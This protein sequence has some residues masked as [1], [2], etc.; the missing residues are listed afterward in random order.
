ML[1]DIIALLGIANPQLALAWQDGGVPTE[2][3]TSPMRLLSNATNGE[4]HAPAAGLFNQDFAKLLS[5]PNGSPPTG[6]PWVLA[7]HPQVGLRLARL[8]GGVLEG[9]TTQ[10]DRVQRPLP[11][12]FAFH[13]TT[14]VGGGPQAGTRAPGERL[15]L[16]GGSISVHDAA[17]QPIDALATACAFA[18]LLTTFPAL[19]AKDF[20][21]TTAPNVASSQLGQLAAALTGTEVRVRLV[22]LFRNPFADG[23]TKLTNLTAIDAAA[24]IYR[25]TN[26]AQPVLV[27]FPPAN[28]NERIAVGAATFGT[29]DST[30]SPQPLGPAV[31]LTTLKRDFLTVFADDLNGHLRGREALVAPYA[32]QDFQIPT[33]HN[34]N[35][36]LLANGNQ[37]LAQAGQV[38]ANA[39]GLSLVVSPVIASDFAVAANAGVSEWPIFPSGGDGAIAGRLQNVALNAHFLAAPADTRDVVLTMEIPESAPSVP[40]LAPGTAVRIYNRKFLADAREGRGNGAGGVLDA[41]RKIGFVLTNPFGLRRDE[42]LPTSPK[43]LFDLIAVNRSGKK[44]SFGL[45]GTDVAAPR[46]PDAAESALADRGAN[47]FNSAPER[48][49]APAGLLGLPAPALSTIPPI[50]DLNSAIDAALSLGDETQPR[51]AP[52][53]PTMTRNELIVA[54][55]AASG[56]WAAVL[57]GLWLRR[58]SRSSLHRLGSP[59][60]PGGEEFLGVG[61]H[62]ASGLLAYD[63]ARMALRRTRGL[64]ERLT[65]LGNDPRWIPPLVAAPAGTFSVAL[66]QDIAPGAD[67]PNL[68]LIPDAIFDNLPNDWTGLVNSINNIIP[69]GLAANAQVRNAINALANNAQG[70]T[71]YSEFK[72]EAVTAR[73]GRRDALPL[74]RAAIKSAR[75]LIY[76]ETSAFSYTDYLPDDQTN[77]HNADDPPNPAT[78]LVSLIVGQLAV[79]PGLKVLIGVSKEF[80]VGIGYETFAARAYD[81]RKKAL[82]DLTAVDPARVTLFH[83]IGF[84]GRPLRLMHNLVIVDD[85]WLFIGSGSF[86][87]RGLLFDGNLALA[88]FDRQIETGRSQAIRN[89]RRQ[90]LE[91]HLDAAPFPGSPPAGFPH[92]NLARAADLHEA[93]FAVRDMLDQG[94]SGFIQGVW[95]GAITG[96]TPIPPASFPHRDLADPDGVGFPSTLAALLQLFAGLGESQA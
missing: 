33:Y 79:Q 72:R 51:V 27:V 80:P 81:R 92:P 93:Y 44:R 86:T 67:S 38:V 42:T 74:L 47:A 23:A 22:S 20:A 77:E 60:S 36:T 73:H 71:L 56:D 64:A 69:A 91:H 59:G 85:M 24:G 26:P 75:E 58:D 89:F 19:I 7:I 34:E 48:G 31:P 62:T 5:M 21:T 30:F 6:T 87:R 28:I 88:C 95:D 4:W 78:D 66:A 50:T 84:P 40:Q 54:G 11:K 17:G 96:Q 39:A 53:L 1:Q 13:D 32:G 94:G 43:L 10:T 83:P 41:N 70:L 3:A 68:K 49:I 90:L 18:A 76:I 46:A 61:A 8:Y 65:E 25:L 45:L 55:R 29:L 16:T 15:E 2:N 57:G 14:N 9:R 37:A 12:Y 63:L 35:L 82:E 52:R